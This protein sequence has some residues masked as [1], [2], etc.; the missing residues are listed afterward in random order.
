MGARTARIRAAAQVMTVSRTLTS[1]RAIGAWTISVLIFL[2]TAISFTQSYRGLLDFASNYLVIPRPFNWTWPMMID[3]FLAVGELRLF[4]CA[5]DGE[6]S[7][8]V[9]MW[10]WLLTGA[11]LAVSV[12]GN[13]MHEGLNISGLQMAGN[14]VPPLAAA[15]ALGTGLGLVKK[16]VARAQAE[17]AKSKIP[18]KPLP[19]TD[20]RKNVRNINSGPRRGTR[21]N[22]LAKDP[23]LQGIVIELR[24]KL[25]AGET[26]SERSIHRDYN[27]SRHMASVLMAAAGSTPQEAASG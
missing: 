6:K 1:S 7:W 26:F 10:F 19:H 11:G 21:K 15:A 20:D 22:A 12:G 23:R 14:A 2:A 25:Q 13:I 5:V 24:R 3:V 17:Q 4:I 27:I 8:R 16:A 9:R 18:D